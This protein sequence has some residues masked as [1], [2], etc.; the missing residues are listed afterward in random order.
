MSAT[1]TSELAKIATWLRGADQAT[2]RS[3]GGGSQQEGRRP[4]GGAGTSVK[5][6]SFLVKFHDS[7]TYD[8]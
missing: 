3:E 7:L 2:T 1:V 4:D 8:S 5:E 6:V